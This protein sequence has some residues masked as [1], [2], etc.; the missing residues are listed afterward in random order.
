M[1]V[2][3]PSFTVPIQSNVFFS[4][5]YKAFQD[6]IQQQADIQ[7]QWVMEQKKERHQMTKEEEDEE[8]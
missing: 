6:R 8:K 7:R 5:L 3:G 2:Y 1:A 4:G